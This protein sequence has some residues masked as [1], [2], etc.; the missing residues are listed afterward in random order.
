[1]VT[2]SEVKERTLLPKNE[3]D[4]IIKT[5]AQHYVVF[6][7]VERRKE[8]S[9]QQVEDASDLKMDYIISTLPPK[10]ILHQPF[11]VLFSFREDDFHEVKGETIPQIIFGI[12]SCD[13]HALEILDKV[14]STDYPDTYYLTR[15]QNTAI[16]ALNCTEVGETC[17]CQSMGTGPELKEGYDLLLT[18]LGEQYL[19]EVGS[20]KGAQI[21][22]FLELQPAPRVKLV[23]KEERINQAKRHFKRQVDTLNLPQVL[24]D[25]FRHPLWNELMEKCLACGSCTMVCPTCFCYNII[26]I[27]DLDLKSGQRQREWDS[28][29]LLEY[30]EVALGHNFRKELDARIKQRIYHKMVYYE[31]Q[32]GTLGCVGCGRCIYTCVAGIDIT[33]VL[34][35][36]RREAK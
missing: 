27:L 17:F 30:A 18:D 13:V 7:P 28:C 31:P 10:K 20:E 36:I 8:V 4:Q 19:V 16:V 34:H 29:M 5:L 21:L 15:R 24:E 22:S 25:N 35:R 6:A 33:D 3:L 11:D 32:F 23:E 1:M 12:H 26:D 9:F 14:Y 2:S